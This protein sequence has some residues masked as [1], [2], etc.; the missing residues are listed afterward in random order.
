MIFRFALRNMLR[1]LWRTA[2][3]FFIVFFVVV[4][5]VASLLIRRACLNAKTTLEEDY[6]FVASLVPK[7]KN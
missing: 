4:S 2:L 3:Y 1:L 5:V 7:K 6:V